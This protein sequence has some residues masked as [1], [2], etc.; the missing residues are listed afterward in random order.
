MSHNTTKPTKWHV[1]PAKTQISLGIRPVWSES[2][3]CAQWVAKDTRVLHADIKDSDQTGQMPRLICVFAG[4]TVSLLVLLCCS[5]YLTSFDDCA[6]LFPSD[7]TL[8]C[9]SACS[10]SDSDSLPARYWSIWS[11]DNWVCRN[12]CTDVSERYSV[13]STTLQIEIHVRL[14]F[15]EIIHHQC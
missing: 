1:H 3:L 5:S 15:F 6:Y 9:L 12:R 13:V 14:I 10:L 7:S 11:H 4:R 2:S 8:H